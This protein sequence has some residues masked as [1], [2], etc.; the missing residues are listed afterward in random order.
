MSFIQTKTS[1]SARRTAAQVKYKAKPILFHGL[2]HLTQ[3]K[4]KPNFWRPAVMEPPAESLKGEI[5]TKAISG[6][7][8]SSTDQIQNQTQFPASSRYRP[9]RGKPQRR[10]ANQSH[11]RSTLCSTDQIQNQ[12]QCPASNRYRHRSR[13]AA[14]EKCKPK[15]FQIHFNSSTDQIQ[16]QTQFPPSIQE[17]KDRDNRTISYD[18]AANRQAIK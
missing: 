11:F 6:P 10:N 8:R 2:L 14:T 18:K 1:S 4:T 3:F 5:Q 16:N 15:P 13:K 7:L 12:S 9:A 17:Q